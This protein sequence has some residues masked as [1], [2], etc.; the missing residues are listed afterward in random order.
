MDKTNNKP[1][2]LNTYKIH[3]KELQSK[4]SG[5][6]SA[7][8]FLTP[9]KSVL[10]TVA[11]PNWPHRGTHVQRQESRGSTE[12]W[13]IYF[14]CGRGFVKCMHIYILHTYFTFH[15]CF[16]CWWL[17]EKKW[18]AKHSLWHVSLCLYQSKQSIWLWFHVAKIQQPKRFKANRLTS[19][20]SL[21][22][23]LASARLSLA[24]L[25]PEESV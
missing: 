6:Q 23:L 15:M 2:N 16:F 1:Y 19:V 24:S 13:M 14:E 7:Y 9:G 12:I 17:C 11:W 10:N 5:A 21:Y 4:L 20:Y 18:F 8:F 3:F 22:P 25:L